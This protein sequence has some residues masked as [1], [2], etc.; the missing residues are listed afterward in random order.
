MKSTSPVVFPLATLSTRDIGVARNMFPDSSDF[1][2]QRTADDVP[3]DVCMEQH[4]KVLEDGEL[5]PETTIVSIFIGAAKARITGANFYIVGRDP[6]GNMSKQLQLHEYKGK[7][8]H[9]KTGNKRVDAVVIDEE[10]VVI[11]EES[12]G[13]ILR[14]MV[15]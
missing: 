3:L 9:A 8:R 2:H 11:D 7:I 10:S 4:S 5:D 12:G 15:H 6:A 14:G 1:I 13:K